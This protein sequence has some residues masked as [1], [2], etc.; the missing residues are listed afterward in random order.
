M[1]SINDLVHNKKIV[2]LIRNHCRA[3]CTKNKKV[4][5]IIRGVYITNRMLN[6]LY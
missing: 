1:V 6:T 3:N 2:P 4:Q 5:Y